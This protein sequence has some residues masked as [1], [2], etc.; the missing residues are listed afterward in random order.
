MSR[1]LAVLVLALGVAGGFFSLGVTGHFD[2]GGR[3]IDLNDLFD[4]PWPALTVLCLPLVAAFVQIFVGRKLPRR[5]DWVSTGAVMVG[6]AIS[7]MMFGR[8]IGIYD[9]Q[10]QRI[11]EIEWIGLFTRSAPGQ[12]DVT[13]FRIPMGILIDNITVIMLVVVTLISTLVHIFS[14]GYM[15]D[16]PR[17]SRFYA[18]LSIFT[19]SMLGLILCHNVFALYMF[20]ELVGL[21]SYLLIGFWFEKKSAADAQKKAFLAN[22]VGDIGMFLGIVTFFYFTGQITYAGIFKGVAEGAFSNHMGLLTIAGCLLF[23]GAIGKSAQFPLH[24]WLPD[25]MEGP[26]PVSALI[27]AATM[28][29]AGVYLVTRMFPVFTPDALIVVA[30]FGGITAIFAATIAL[31][32]NDIKKVLAYSTVSQ[33]GYMIMG[34]GASAYTNGF[35]HLW[36]HAFFKACLFLGSGSVIHAVH[37]QDMREMGGLWK[38]MPITFGAMLLSTFA[39]AGVP[40]TSGFTS[41]DGILGDLLFAAHH[42][43]ALWPIVVFA[44]VGAG[45][46]AFYMFRLIF[47]T[48]TGKPKV[49]EKFDHAH[50]SPWVMAAPL[51]I[52]GAL[53]IL[54]DKGGWFQELVGPPPSAASAAIRMDLIAHGQ[55]VV[56]EA[57]ESAHEGGEHE[58]A[59]AH[60]S[61]EAASAETSTSA[62][63]H[64][65]EDPLEHEKHPA[66]T[67]AMIISIFVAGSGIFLSWLTYQKK[68]ISAPKIA[69]ALPGVHNLLLNKYYVDEFITY[70][71]VQPFLALAY[72]CARFDL[73]VIDFTVNAWGYFTVLCSRVA[74]LFD[75]KVVDGTVNGTADVVQS[76]GTALSRFQ[77]GRIKTY[78]AWSVAGALLLV[79]GFH[80]VTNWKHV[81]VRRPAA[82]VEPAK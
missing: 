78:L 16:E 41:K 62:R 53:A 55:P 77:T 44:F 10:F 73:K 6:L 2:F 46:T 19:F 15:V 20:W 45:L 65:Y 76:A 26:T 58:S 14:M 68:V 1:G 66:H 70:F 59:E 5:G 52:L 32:A 64:P 13:S 61:N 40:G 24:V 36:T 80:L 79:G 48:F 29:A 63:R 57:K 69:A 43:A 82:V 50:E 28:V 22:R 54:S 39:I 4:T 74:G 56:E 21:S 3:V 7:L 12:P 67:T 27:H 51:V 38:K 8:M 35:F 25:A 75:Q 72:G 23:C 30:W 37:T 33:L 71:L 42:H 18:F 34:L 49:Q 17:Y 47:M 60:P 81:F 9:W 11:H 31:C